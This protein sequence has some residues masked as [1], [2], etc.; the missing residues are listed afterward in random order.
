MVLSDVINS[1]P[2][3]ITAIYRPVLEFTDQAMSMLG[4]GLG[5]DVVDHQRLRGFMDRYVTLRYV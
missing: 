2:Y 4:L 1:S 3:H 5:V